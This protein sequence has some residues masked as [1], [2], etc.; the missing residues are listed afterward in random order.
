MLGMKLIFT[1]KNSKR[2]RELSKEKDG[3][4]SALAKLIIYVGFQLSYWR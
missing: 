3:I 2:V 4:G 1:I